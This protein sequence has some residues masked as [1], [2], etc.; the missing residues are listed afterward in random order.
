M[1]MG[2]CRILLH[3]T[4]TLLC[5]TVFSCTENVAGG[6]GSTT[7]N[8]FTVQ[9]VGSSGAPLGQAEVRVRP[10][11]YCVVPTT[12]SESQINGTV[13]DTITDANGAIVIGGLVPG[14]YTVEIF[15]KKAGEGVVFRRKIVEGDAEKVGK[16]V[17]AETGS[18]QGVFV[19]RLESNGKRFFVQVYGMERIAGVDSINGAY[20][21]SGLPPSEYS[22]RIVCLDTMEVPI[23][24]PVVTVSS[25]KLVQ[26]EKIT[27]WQHEGVVRLN[28]AIAGLGPADTLFEFPLLLR[29]TNANFDF[30]SAK[31]KGEDLRVVKPNNALVSFE[32]E[33]WD[34]V[35]GSAVVWIK[36]DTLCGSSPEK[37]MHLYWGNK[38]SSAFSSGATVFDTASGFRNVWHLGESGGKLE[39]DA[40]VNNRTGT[41]AGMDG[42]NDVAGIAGRAQVFDD[43][44]QHINFG[45]V[46]GVN[47]ADSVYSF[48]LWVKPS[49]NGI[50]K[51]SVFRFDNSGLEIDSVNNWIFSIDQNQSCTTTVVLGQWSQVTCIR[52]GSRSY[53]YLNDHLAD[54]VIVY[55]EKLSS[56][57]SPGDTLFLGWISDS[58][59]W[60]SG[61]VDEFRIYSQVV[62]PAWVRLC[63]A[64]QK[65]IPDG[66][67]FEVIK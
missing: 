41:P 66:V 22:L 12:I 1:K 50:G 6:S 40:T 10:S 42:A 18:V 47:E 38:N 5:C 4:L 26:I 58:T 67:R 49:G 57:Q 55:T 56:I 28:A 52:D 33:Q 3:I 51:R 43:G 21:I 7:T 17:A 45:S 63:Y 31:K 23:D 60:Y 11:G 9:V 54:S 39:N 16:L 15:S 30:S 27:A 2:D 34:S 46:S 44:S 59:G 32:I 35:N 19:Q 36:I 20:T 61:I 13:I 64:T 62:V 25:G 48:S 65:E 29:L 8:G 37:T 24:I 53:L 14:M